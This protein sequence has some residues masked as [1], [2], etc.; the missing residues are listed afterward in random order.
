M[1]L[2]LLTPLAAALANCPDVPAGFHTYLGAPVTAT[3]QLPGLSLKRELD[4]LRLQVAWLSDDP[5]RRFRDQNLIDIDWLTRTHSNVDVYDGELQAIRERDIHPVKL[6]S[7]TNFETGQVHLITCEQA[8]RPQV[9]AVLVFAYYGVNGR[10]MPEQTR[11]SMLTDES[12]FRAQ[13]AVI[14]DS[15]SNVISET[16]NGQIDQAVLDDV[17]TVTG[18]RPG[19]F[20]AQSIL[21][22]NLVIA[23]HLLRNNPVVF[24]GAK[25]ARV[26]QNR[27][28]I[29]ADNASAV[30]PITIAAVSSG[31][32][33]IMGPG[34]R[35]SGLEHHLGSLRVSSTISD[36]VSFQQVIDAR[37]DFHHMATPC[38]DG[39][40]QITAEFSHP[41]DLS[42]SI[43][44]YAEDSPSPFSSGQSLSNTV[45][46]DRD[47]RLEACR[48]LSLNGQPETL[49][50]TGPI[51]VPLATTDTLV[52]VHFSPPFAS[53]LTPVTIPSV[54]TV[55]KLLNTS[56][57]TSLYGTHDYFCDS[58]GDSRVDSIDEIA[59]RRNSLLTAD[60]KAAL[61]PYPDPE[62]NESAWNDSNGDGSMCDPGETDGNPQRIS[63]NKITF[64]VY[65]GAG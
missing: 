47:Y 19:H 65:P 11:V 58:P 15:V 38:I 4:L 57:I 28:Y 64:A 35:V 8:F 41:S 55:L 36:Q 49:S 22:Q 56:E 10:I 39:S 27:L 14:N 42:G 53:G 1:L 21:I 37:S 5:E 32:L 61:G 33:D 52:R 18:V 43:G 13:T 7:N 9:G 6:A 2:L 16:F 26:V 54:E 60:E 51:W 30:L 12:A 46:C 44:L 31:G 29:T 25:N 62:D 17:A 23:Q 34:R 50:E 63:I 20:L 59:A 45:S 3:E 24:F 40:S 48:E